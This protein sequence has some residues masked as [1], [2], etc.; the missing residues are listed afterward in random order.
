[1][2]SDR[3][4]G[5]DI[6]YMQVKTFMLAI[7]FNKAVEV[8]RVINHL[9]RDAYGNWRPEDILRKCAQELGDTR[10]RS[11]ML[12]LVQDKNKQDQA[13]KFFKQSSEWMSR[14]NQ[15]KQEWHKL[16]TAF[17]QPQKPE[18]QQQKQGAQQPKA[19]KLQN[20]NNQL[21][22]NAQ[23]KNVVPVKNQH[24]NRDRHH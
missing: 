17:L 5:V 7:M 4:P 2:S 14:E 6:D 10:H 21:A 11:D 20:Q 15:T 12:K 23:A 9:T 8:A 24:G 13:I 22:P 1:M 19:V 16:K 18:D 3:T